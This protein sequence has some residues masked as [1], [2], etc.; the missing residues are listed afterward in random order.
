M[1]KRMEW[2]KRYPADYCRKT[3]HLSLELRGAYS[4]CLDYIYSEETPI[5]LDT[6]LFA[7]HL[8]VSKA[9][10]EGLLEILVSHGLL[11]KT[12]A[13]YINPRAEEELTIRNEMR[14]EKSAAA[15]KR[16]QTKRTKPNT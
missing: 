10:W 4:D 16:E 3:R 14:R 7:H 1:T 15:A 11:I 9:K 13:G 12:R 2:Y 6:Q 8:H 5:P